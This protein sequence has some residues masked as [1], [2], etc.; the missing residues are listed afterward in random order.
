[1]KVAKRLS[2]VV[3][4]LA[5]LAGCITPETSQMAG[6]SMHS[7]SEAVSVSY[8]NNDSLI[9]RNLNIAM[10]YNNHFKRRALPIK[11]VVMTPDSLYFEDSITLYPRHPRQILG[12]A[13]VESLPYR[14]NV[15][16]NRRGPY[17]FTIEPYDEVKGVEA[18]GVELK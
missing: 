11:I 4:A 1:M 13:T 12:M 5:F 15:L 16:L 3:V 18:I 10:R 8:I 6:V 14:A 17:T 2:I 7:W 9:V